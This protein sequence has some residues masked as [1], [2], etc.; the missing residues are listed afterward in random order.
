MRS[1][2]T[3][4]MVTVVL[5][6]LLD[7]AVLRPV[8]GLGY[9]SHYVQENLQRAPAPYIGFK[10][11]ANAVDHDAAGYRRSASPERRPDA[12]QVAFFGGSSGYVGDPPIADLLQ[13]RLSKRLA[14]PVA[15]ANFSVVSS[16]HR[17]HL[18]NV[19]ESRA[20]LQPD[21]VIFYGGYNET[22][23]SAYYDP[24]PG[25]PYNFFF[26]DETAPWKRALLQYSA[27]AGLMDMAAQ[28]HL[29]ASLT[30]LARLRAEHRP[31]SPEWNRQIEDKYFETLMLAAAV[32][33]TFPSPRC[34]HARFIA[35]Y[36]PF[37]VA[38]AFGE[39][40][41]RIRARVAALPHGADVSQALEGKS[42]WFEDDVHLLQAGNERM[43]DVMADVIVERGFLSACTR[44]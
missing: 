21:V 11:K 22:M 10:G 27:V 20:Q 29:G 14:R 36:Q 19:V 26:R 39:A 13:S 44:P 16:N 31:L 41:A 5:L 18:H 32:V 17:Q 3:I 9:P 25:Y 42:N 33:Q 15:I 24:R 4:V 23:Q 8:F 2:A 38:P 28:K 34:G 35:F 40:H 7:V 37:K 12:L 43:A 30:P 6:V 1:F